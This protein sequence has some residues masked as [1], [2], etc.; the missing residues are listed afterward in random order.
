M[1][2]PLNND[3][4]YVLG[5]GVN[6]SIKMIDRQPVFSPPLSHNFFKIA[7]NLPK[8][9]FRD[10]DAILSPLYDYIFK[11]WRKSKADLEID[12]FNLE[13]CF[14]LI[15]LQLT[16]ARL[17][18]DNQ[19]VNN[20]LKIQYFL[21]AFF[22]EVLSEF[23]D[24]C[25]L[26]PAMLGFG[27]V[28]YNEQPMI[29]T[30]NYDLFIESVIEHGSGKNSPDLDYLNRFQRELTEGELLTIVSNSEWKW[31]C[32]LAYGIKFDRVLLHDGSI[33]FREKHFDKR[34]FYSHK[35]IS[36]ILGV[37]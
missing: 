23:G 3:I 24:Y 32:P 28:L 4:V 16:E 26:S 13:E 9:R 19:R 11:Y 15:Q 25:L 1:R 27:N 8:S 14:T 5:A 6:Q 2:H 34:I 7:R 33:A 30:F 12:D 20:L 37:Y 10:Y 31:N 22:V 36:S 17:E 29:I 18:K 35:K 21:V